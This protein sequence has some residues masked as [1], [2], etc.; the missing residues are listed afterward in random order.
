[1]EQQQE[2]DTLL[3]NLVDGIQNVRAAISVPAAAARITTNSDA[4]TARTDTNPPAPRFNNVD[5]E[6]RYSSS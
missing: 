6:M 4:R 5:A 2:I 3:G 1:M